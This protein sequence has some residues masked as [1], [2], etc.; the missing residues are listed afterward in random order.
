MNKKI[1]IAAVALV[2]VLGLM[3]GVWLLTRPDSEEG[4]KTITV[5]ICHADGTDNS[6][7]WSTDATTLAEAMNEKNLLAD[8][9]DGMYLTVDGETTDYSA[10]QSWWCLYVND[11][12]A[13]E[14]ADTIQIHDGDDFRWEYTIGF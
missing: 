5:T 7:S 14:G 1:L 11:V 6:Y 4:M 12:S 13:V 9:Q 2:A 3:A 10:N 8:G